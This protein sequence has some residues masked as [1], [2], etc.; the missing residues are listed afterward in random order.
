MAAIVGGALLA[1]AM[2]M[3][4]KKIVSREFVALLRR[5][6][7]DD[8]L[9]EKLKITLLSLQS[10]LYDAEDKQIT[11]PAVKEWL[12][13]LQDAVFQVDDLFDEINTE[14]LRHQ[15]EAGQVLKKLSSPFK[16]FNKKINSKLTKL[17]KKLE[18]LRD[19]N[20]GLRGDSNCVWNVTPTSS[21][22][23]DESA[24]YGRDD[25]KNKLKELL[26]SEDGCDSENKIG[27]ISIVGMGGL[28]KSTLAKLL[29]NDTVVKD[30]FKV[31]GWSHIPK[32]MDVVTVTKTIL[33]S[34]T[35]ETIAE[36]NFVK[37]QE[38]LQQTLSGK[39]F[40]LVLDDMSHE[41]YVDWNSLSDI[42]NVGQIGS[43]VI[44]T[45]RDE[46]VALPTLKSLYVH[47][48]SSL[49]TEDSWSLLARHAFV[50]RNYQQY[51]DLEEIGREIAK[52]CGGLP[53]AAI[54]LGGILRFMSPD[55][56]SDVLNNSIW[57]QT[58]DAVQ[59]ALLLSYRY[60]PTS[61]KGC[62]AYCS[63][64]P[65]NSILVKRMVVQL[66]IAEDLIPQ[67]NS[68]KSWEKVAEEYFDELV[69]RSLILQRSID[70]K[71]KEFTGDETACFEMHDL[72]NDLAMTVS[73]PFCSRLDKHKPD[74]RV[75]ERV[76][77]LSYD[78]LEYNSSDKFDL[79]HG[80]KG[81][82]TFL[83]MPLQV[84]WEYSNSVLSKLF[85]DLLSNMTQLHV[86][87]LSH[88]ENFTELPISIGKLIYLRYL[89]L[90]S[91]R[92]KR[93][94]S[95]TCK[96]YNLQTLLLSR[97]K[98]LTELPKDM[99]KL[100]KLRHLDI[101]G[102]KLK[103]MPA[104]MSKLKNLHTLS[105]FIVSSVKDFG[106]KIG[107][108]GK[109]PYLRGSLSI[110]QLENVI[111]SSHA[112][113][114]NLEMK[115]EIDELELGWSYTAPSNSQIQVLERLRPSKNLKSLTISGYGG[116]KLSNWVGD[117][118]FVNMVCLKITWCNKIS[119]L[120]SLG[121]LSN[122]KE[123]SFVGMQSVKS[124]D[125]MFYGSGYSS[126]QPFISLETL[127]FEDMAE[128]EEWK[129]IGGTSIEF[130]SL[131]R[132]SLSRCP[133]LKENIPGNLPKLESLSLEN[134]P[135]LI[136][137]TPN[138][139]P[140][141]A[142]LRLEDCPLLTGS[143]HSIT[144]PP[145]DVSQLVNC[146][147]SLQKLTLYRI[148]SL[149]SF[150]IDGLPKTLR[151]LYIDYCENLEFFS[152]K[153]FHNY[154]LLEYLNISSSCN[155]M[156]S[157]IL[158]S[159]PVLK[160]L[161]IYGC[162]HLK[163]ISIAEDASEQNLVFLRTIIIESCNELESVSLTGL[164]IPNLTDLRVDWCEKLSSLS[165]SIKNLTSL[166][167]MTITGLP[168]L[169]S[170]PIDDIPINLRGLSV[171]K[172]GGI[173]WNST[174]EH[175]TSLS[176]LDIEGDDIVKGLMKRK[177]PFLPT[178]LVSLGIFRLEDIECL[179]GKWL[180]HLSTLH[181]LEI[182]NSPNLKSLPEKGELPSSLKELY[183]NFCPLLKENLRR[184]KGK[185]WLK[186]CHIPKIFI[187]WKIIE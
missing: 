27:V 182:C 123:L 49:E 125:T 43:K 52:K 178:N 131:I 100:V 48:L 98:E 170:F 85:S 50:E 129:L 44:I 142:V 97:C 69:S 115:K 87:S 80:L 61:L 175:L 171:G 18:Q 38:K 90:S 186:I 180:Q 13:R 40:L 24:I 159:L 37:L 72:I 56:W 147:N 135:E 92:I 59:P 11:N 5:T 16:R 140:S 66:W 7:R 121:K 117:P 9:L 105:D 164:P 78:R 108:L 99:G 187:N 153:S 160:S 36:T 104:Q 77:H 107:D 53:L 82:R 1:A 177:V 149:T 184:K 30:T 15:V 174:W 137:M 169:Q 32:V 176:K 84:S 21:V 146:L 163:S 126:F 41:N 158:G 162:E 86:L 95:E 167:E 12:N 116:D 134:C 154:S 68:E 63:I 70:D 46:R 122:L 73:S 157:F 96:L 152:H 124:V 120:P 161:Y 19:Q 17:F 25:D 144:N 148:P 42:F 145:S 4:V 106:L 62:F 143:T 47:R 35:A 2:E 133:K 75:D 110:S 166:Q 168:N 65:K 132:L 89:N 91:T 103:R 31:R 185:E 172:V 81:L 119:V 79:L 58:N 118:L 6:E 83:P 74:E 10:V 45:G 94:P 127:S 165:E 71:S 128:W 130:P 183:I 88:F 112:F 39:M 23:G 57:E 20:L 14:A 8:E 3:L 51:P 22:L 60:L 109:Y 173:L 114:A 34:V 101:S 141:L 150:P 113:E 138:N 111:D 67:Q 102:T 33:E 181:K 55:R 179:D 156:T 151:S 26:L 64:F 139:L 136:G 54:A 28:G 29:Y 93:L 155:S 76:R